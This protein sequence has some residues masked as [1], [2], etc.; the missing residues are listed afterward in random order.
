MKHWWRYW[1]KVIGIALFVWI[2]SNTDRQALAEAMT[3]ADMR[4]ILVSLLL[5]PVIYSV[6]ALRWHALIQTKDLHMRFSDAFHMYCS[7]LLLGVVTPGKAGEAAR[8]PLLRKNGLSM[9]RSIIVTIADRLFDVITL[10]ILSVIAVSLLLGTKTAIIYGCGGAIC[11]L[12]LIQFLRRK[13]LLQDILFEAS[14]KAPAL[15]LLTGI[16]WFVYFLQMVVLSRAFGLNVPLIPFLSSMVL[17][18]LVTLLPIAPLGLGTRDGVLLWFYEPYGIASA[19]T[20][21]FS[22][23]IAALTLLAITVVGGLSFFS[24]QTKRP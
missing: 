11:G 1:P 13:N 15:T 14:R 6:K 5:F 3:E 4:Y 8:I 12:G 7:T 2:L 18:G 23:S 17:S 22:Y 9:K 19:Q 21:S 20:L 16:N 10:G 24:L